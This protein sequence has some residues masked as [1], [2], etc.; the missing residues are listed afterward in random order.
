MASIFLC[1]SLTLSGPSGEAGMVSMMFNISSAA[2][3]W[4]LGG[5][6]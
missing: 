3:P 6:S 2:I 4:P 1:S 5:N